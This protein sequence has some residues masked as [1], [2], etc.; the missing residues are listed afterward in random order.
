LQGGIPQEC[1]LVGHKL[2]E[3]R[4][5]ALSSTVVQSN[6]EDDISERINRKNKPEK[7]KFVSIDVTAPL[8]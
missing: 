6:N 2:N 3:A 4:Q 7:F 8:L 1:R 5:N